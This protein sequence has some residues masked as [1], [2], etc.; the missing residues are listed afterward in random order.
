MGRSLFGITPSVNTAVSANKSPKQ[1]EVS[2]G[3]LPS[4]VV[5][6]K[7][8]V[9][10]NWCGQTKLVESETIS[11]GDKNLNFCRKIAHES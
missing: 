10:V 9:V 11:K 3:R 4:K 1:S 5:C 2:A 6:G 7:K 8:P